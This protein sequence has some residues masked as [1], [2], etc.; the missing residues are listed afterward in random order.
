MRGATDDGHLALRVKDL[1][2]TFRRRGQDDVEAVRGISF[3]VPVG[4]VLGLLGPNGAGKS[5]T[6][7]CILGLVARDEGHVEVY[8]W[9]A[10]HHRRRAMKLM[11]AVLEGSRNVYWRLTPRE[12]MDYFA[13]IHGCDPRE[14]SAYHEHLLERLGLAGR[15]DRPVMELSQGMKQKVAI[16]C[17]LA[18]RA[19]LIFLDEP[20]LGLDV[21][22]S[23]EMR[24]MLRDLVEEE[25]KTVLISSHDMKVVEDVCE[26]VIIIKEGAVVVDDATQNLLSLFRTRAYRVELAGDLDAGDLGR[27]ETR[28]SRVKLHR[29][30]HMSDLEVEVAEPGDL[31]ELVDTLRAAGAVIEGI[32]RDQP[33][34]E[35]A[36]LSIIQSDGTPM[37]EGG[38][39]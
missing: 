37:S 27:L 21:E 39:R 31:Y 15:A 20:T 36:F 19:P 6:I 26:R 38:V 29:K 28:F 9:N 34:L 11:A 14:D 1:K 8:G 4:S 24:A 32:Y 10:D 2:K 23:H 17:T 12:N 35:R 33:D 25:D 18:R 16:A 30:A 22:T 3:D 13:S 7:K 5:T